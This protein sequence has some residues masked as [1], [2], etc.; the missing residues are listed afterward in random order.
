MPSPRSPRIPPWGRLSAALFVLLA[1]CGDSGGGT[2]SAQN[3]KALKWG[4]GKWG[5]NA[6]AAATPLT[7]EPDAAAAGLPATTSPTTELPGT[8]ISR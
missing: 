6:W 3:P 4:S 8:E 2:G 1:A 7:L 5:T